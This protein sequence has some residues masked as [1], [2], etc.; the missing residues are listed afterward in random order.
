M[1]SLSRETQHGIPSP[2]PL[3]A[4]RA[5][6]PSEAMQK[7]AREL[8]ESASDAGPPMPYMDWFLAT[9]TGSGGGGTPGVVGE[10]VSKG[11]ATSP[12]RDDA[13][14]RPVDLVVASYSLCEIHRRSFNRVV[15]ALWASTTDMLVLI[16]PGTPLGFRNIMRAR[17]LVLAEAD[18][19]AG[20]HV[21]APCPHDGP[22]PLLIPDK[23][24]FAGAVGGWCRRGDVM[25]GIR[26]AESRGQ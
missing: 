6:E 16:E 1:P 23:L 20:A 4:R 10:P 13:D 17:E 26:S 8:Y 25:G 11:D 3:P 14:R 15:R 24:N 19:D 9:A 7:I 22:C 5:V 12:G 18:G 2:P 21:V